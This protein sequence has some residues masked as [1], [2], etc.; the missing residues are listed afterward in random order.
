MTDRLPDVSHL[1]HGM[2]V[3]P[4]PL[5]FRSP[6]WVNVYTFTTSAGTTLLDCGTD[7]EPGMDRLREGLRLLEIDPGSID[8]L[9]VTHLHPDHVGMS[10]RV[11]QTF[12]AV[13]VMHR[14]AADRY[15]G[16]NDREGF[17]R[18]TALFGRLH[19]V[20]PA[21]QE[22]FGDV[23]RP[24]W[25]PDIAPPDVVVDDGGTIDIGDGRSLEVLHTPGHDQSHICLVE[26]MTGILFS[27]DHILP[28]I[29]PVIMWDATEEDVLDAY[30]TSLRRLVAEEFGLTYP[31]HGTIVERGSLRAEQIILHHDRRLSGMLDIVS[32][33]PTTAWGVMTE[34]FRPNLNVPEQRLA[35]R[36]TVSHLEHLRSG[37]TVT[38]F[39]ESVRWYRRT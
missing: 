31:A 5:P 9:V 29:T 3:I 18:W 28:R 35:L 10:R 33:G 27:G 15:R 7:W 11:A 22:A 37:G 8:R 36:E 2:G 38:S 34:S 26:S 16:Y 25:M 1:G 21:L 6:A 32:L 23:E 12:G 17:A 39:D 24:D 20:P 19:G 4:V 14:S 13:T 30:L